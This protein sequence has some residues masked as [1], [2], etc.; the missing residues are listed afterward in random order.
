MSRGGESLSR[1]KLIRHLADGTRQLWPDGVYK[2]FHD[3]YSMIA[4]SLEGYYRPA[5]D[6]VDSLS[7]TLGESVSV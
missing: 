5:R 6:I 1:E 2:A 3:G 4:A 7:E